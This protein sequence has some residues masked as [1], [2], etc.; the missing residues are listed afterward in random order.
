L[1]DR[2]SWRED[3]GG[4]CEGEEEGEEEGGGSHFVGVKNLKVTTALA[5]EQKADWLPLEQGRGREG[6]K[7][8]KMG[9]GKAKCTYLLDAE[10]RGCSCCA[11]ETGKGK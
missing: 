10:V 1:V 8:D 11:N 9:S 7:E 4:G 3:G 5:A 6:K 2:F